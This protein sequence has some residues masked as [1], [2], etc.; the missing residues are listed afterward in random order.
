MAALRIAAL[1]SLISF[2]CVFR[3]FGTAPDLMQSFVLVLQL[4]IPHLLV[5]FLP[6]RLAIRIGIAQGTAVIIFF[7]MVVFFA[8]V[9][10]VRNLL[11]AF[12]NDKWI[13]WPWY[14]V[15]VTHAGMF[16]AARLAKRKEK[17]A[18]DEI[19]LYTIFAVAYS[20]FSVVLLQTT[21]RM[22]RGH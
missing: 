15:A 16:A 18:G 7:A 5:V 11:P 19:G 20:S 12:S 17:P 3:Q 22:L 8:L 4:G 6:R 14:L 21:L 10:F 1:V 9:V 13:L 2:L